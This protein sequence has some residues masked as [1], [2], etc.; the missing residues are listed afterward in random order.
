[1]SRAWFSKYATQI[2]VYVTRKTAD[3]G[4]AQYSQ[5]IALTLLAQCLVWLNVVLW[6]IVGVVQALG[7][8]L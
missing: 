2:P 6:G 3:G 8:L 1:M 7:M 4:T 5:S